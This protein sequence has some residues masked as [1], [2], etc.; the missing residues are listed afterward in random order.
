MRAD[1]TMLQVI[2][3]KPSDPCSEMLSAQRCEYRLACPRK[4]LTVCCAACEF[5]VRDIKSNECKLRKKFKGFQ[6]SVT[7]K[8]NFRGAGTTAMNP[9]W[10]GRPVLLNGESLMEVP[11]TG[12][13][14]GQHSRFCSEKCMV[15]RECQYWFI[16]PDAA[17]CTLGTAFTGFEASTMIHGSFKYFETAA[18]ECRFLGT[19]VRMHSQTSVKK[20]S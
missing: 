5:W 19:P 12:S 18:S 4:P 6:G 15:N 1:V 16:D 20:K 9:A 3:L 14:D 11:L 13:T 8:G 10:L 2:L 7:H 17:Q